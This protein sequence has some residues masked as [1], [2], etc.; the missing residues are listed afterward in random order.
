MNKQ[1]K[2]LSIIVVAFALALMFALAGCGQQASSSSAAASSESA[3]ASAASTSAASTSAT[4]AS[5]T[6]ASTSATSA[7]TTAASTSATSASTNAAPA[8]AS[9]GAASAPATEPA[10][11]EVSYTITIDASDADKGLL[12]EGIGT[13]KKG[14]TVYDVLIDTELDLSV[15]TSSGSTYVDGIADVVA[16]EVGPNAGWLF[17][18]NGESPNAGADAYQISDGDEIVWKFTSDF[19]A[20]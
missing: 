4:S 15:I 2:L 20:Q 7:S 8:A 16:S 13:A 1:T 10:A 6:A 14:A 11:D 5:T 17:T 12:F 9:T 18:V 19:S 3:S